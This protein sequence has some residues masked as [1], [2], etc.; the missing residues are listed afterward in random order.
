[1]EII[2]HSYNFNLFAKNNIKPDSESFFKLM[3]L[4]QDGFMPTTGEE[5]NE[6]G[7]KNK[8]L[9]IEK[10]DDRKNISVTFSNKF[11]STQ[12]TSD[13]IIDG[14]RAFVILSTVTEKLSAIFSEINGNRVSC[15]ANV[16][17]DNDRDT[18]EAIYNKYFSDN[19]EYFEWN[20]RRAKKSEIHNEQTFNVI[21][22]NKGKATKINAGSLSQIDAIIISADNNTTPE[23]TEFRFNIRNVN[24]FKEL[25]SACDR[26]I[27][28]IMER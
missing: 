15:I 28:S 25:M 2:G 21:T 6:D 27:T 4:I 13:T 26:D 9:R 3:P 10:D 24:I 19:N 16:I 20:I 18:E 7:T 22:I 5:V 23:N 17:I 11:I 8:I 14:E 12:I 1:M